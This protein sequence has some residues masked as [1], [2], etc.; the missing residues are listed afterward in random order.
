MVDAR[1]RNADGAPVVLEMA[2]AI[3][4]HR[5]SLSDIDGLIGDGDHGINMNKGFQLCRQRLD[6]AAMNLSAS[7]RLLGDILMDE[8]GGS[9]GPLYGMAFRAMAR[10]CKD[11]DWIDGD[12]FADMLL[13]AEEKVRVIGECEEGE[14]TLLDVLAPARRAFDATW[15]ETGDFALALQAMREAADAGREAT[16][17]MLARKGRS[18]R[19]GERSRGV[20]DAGATSCA[21]LLESISR[22]VRARL[23][24]IDGPQ[25]ERAQRHS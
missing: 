19:L 23:L 16:I 21:L 12:V 22:E 9:M 1:F 2:D 14:K 6:P 17:G 5:Q 4:R 7:L 8:I 11:A 18:S 24:A 15:V 10:S 3:A 13:K 25:V 20:A